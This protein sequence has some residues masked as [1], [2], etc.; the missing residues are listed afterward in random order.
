MEWAG[1]VHWFD[2]YVAH[3]DNDRCRDN[4]F[5]VVK[6]DG[7]CVLY[8]KDYTVLLQLLVDRAIQVV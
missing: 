5:W 8:P 7:P 2:I 1:H 4:C 6:P 3:R